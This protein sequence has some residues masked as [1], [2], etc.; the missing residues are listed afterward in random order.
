MEFDLDRQ[1]QSPSMF[2]G[3][4]N[5]YSKLQWVQQANNIKNKVK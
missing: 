5:N 4:P 2:S 3:G 1:S